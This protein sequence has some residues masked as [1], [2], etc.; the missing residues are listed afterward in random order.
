MNKTF[1]YSPVEEK[2]NAATH[3][4]GIFFSLYVLITLSTKAAP[5]GLVAV[6]SYIIFGLS[7]VTMFTCSTVYHLEKREKRKLFMKK[8]DHM[9]IFILIAG[10]ITPFLLVNLNTQKGLWFCVFI[11]SFALGGIIFKILGKK[12]RRKLSLFFYLSMGWSALFIAPD[13]KPVI[14]PESLEFIIYGGLSY[15]VGVIFYVK[16][17]LPHHHMIWHLFVMG[18]TYFHYLAVK[19]AHP[20][21]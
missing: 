17:K 16:K 13:L 10:S 6:S 7:M 18:G 5:L 19:V 12:E 2:L 9:A 4:L 20:I 15:S 11:W 8:L 21:Q 14:P 3:F 1:Q